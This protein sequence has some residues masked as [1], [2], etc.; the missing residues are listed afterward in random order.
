MCGVGVDALLGDVQVID[1]GGVP[2]VQGDVFPE[3]GGDD[4][5]SPVPAELVGCFAYVGG[6]VACGWFVVEGGVVGAGEGIG[7]LCEP[8]LNLF[9]G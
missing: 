1:A 6:A 7:L 5:R 4:A 2:G 8:G 9:D 3:A